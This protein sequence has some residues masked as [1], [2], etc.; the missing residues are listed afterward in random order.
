MP[1]FGRAVSRPSVAAGE[2]VATRHASPTAAEASAA[3]AV[4]PNS[5][6]ESFMARILLR[7]VTDCAVAIARQRTKNVQF[8]TNAHGFRSSAS[9][10][11][12]THRQS[13][14][15]S[16]AAATS[17]DYRAGRQRRLLARSGAAGAADHRRGL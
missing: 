12:R 15:Q 10:L 1:L 8:V 3:P 4:N 11:R 14:T 5:R 2:L 7:R 9:Q 13:R 17:P 16:P 6:R